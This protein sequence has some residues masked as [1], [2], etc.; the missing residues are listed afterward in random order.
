MLPSIQSTRNSIYLL[1]ST[2][3][4]SHWWKEW[5]IAKRAL[6]HTTGY[7]LF[8]VWHKFIPFGYSNLLFH[9][10]Q[11]NNKEDLIKCLHK[12]YFKSTNTMKKICK[13]S[14][15]M[16]FLFIFQCD[17]GCF[18]CFNFYFGVIRNSLQNI[19]TGRS[20]FPFTQ[21]LLVVA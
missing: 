17:A 11:Q 3:M 15:W 5:Q 13:S 9:C 2:S 8:L 20:H 21:L 4:K 19:Y 12:T 16:S 10:I 6:K 14:T 18:V 1:I 7:Y